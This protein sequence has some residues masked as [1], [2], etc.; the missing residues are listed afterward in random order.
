MGSKRR[1]EHGQLA[2]DE[3]ESL[4]ERGKVRIP[5]RKCQVLPLR[6]VLATWHN[7]VSGNRPLEEAH[8]GTTPTAQTMVV[9]VEA[10][11]VVHHQMCSV[12]LI[13]WRIQNGRWISRRF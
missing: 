8:Y 3:Y 2:K 9:I 7:A 12:G 4:M 1:N 6:R 11:V 10:T 13:L 5:D